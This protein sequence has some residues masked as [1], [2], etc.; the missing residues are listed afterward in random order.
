MGFQRLESTYK[1]AAWIDRAAFRPANDTEIG[2][3][4]KFG[5][6]MG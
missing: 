5:G 6:F 3:F 1:Q 4:G 2:Y